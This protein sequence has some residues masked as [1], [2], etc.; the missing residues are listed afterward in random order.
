[1]K[2]NTRCAG[3]AIASSGDNDRKSGG[4]RNV[5]TASTSPVVLAVAANRAGAATALPNCVYNRVS[6]DLF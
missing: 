2:S 3:T 5:A 6:Y 1:M 4:S